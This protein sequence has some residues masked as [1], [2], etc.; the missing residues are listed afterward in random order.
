[1]NT[2]SEKTVEC[3]WR[4]LVLSYDSLKTAVIPAVHCTADHSYVGEL[5]RLALASVFAAACR[6]YPYVR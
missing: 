4:L 6:L 2:Y 1:M 5:P 3:F